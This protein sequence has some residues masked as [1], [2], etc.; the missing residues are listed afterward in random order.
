MSILNWSLVRRL[1]LMTLIAHPNLHSSNKK[2]QP[3]LPSRSGCYETHFPHIIHL[4]TA[5]KYVDN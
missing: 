1:S 2:H 5:Y 3:D 4:H